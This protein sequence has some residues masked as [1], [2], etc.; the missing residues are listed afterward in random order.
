[1]ASLTPQVG[2][3]KAGEG[4]WG[5][6]VRIARETQM[7]EVRVMEE[8]DGDFLTNIMGRYGKNIR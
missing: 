4:K 1:M 5:S 8:S 6:C 7:G 2:T 3:F